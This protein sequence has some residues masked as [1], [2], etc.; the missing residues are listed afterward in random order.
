MRPPRAAVLLAAVFALLFAAPRA[1]AQ[2]ETD[3]GA[4]S[5]SVGVSPAGASVGAGSSLASPAALS[6][7][8]T[9]SLAP[10]LSAPLSA[11]AAAGAVALPASAISP[12]RPA[13]VSAPAAEP[14]AVAPSAA[15]HAAP[16]A[17]PAA[18]V[19]SAEIAGPPLPYLAALKRLGVP[20]ELAAGLHD[21]LDVR[22]PGDQNSIYHGAGHTREV[23]GFTARLVEGQDLPAA[24][25]ILLIFAAALH[26]IDPDRAPNTPARVSATLEHLDKD[27]Q[28]R[29]LVAE[30]GARYGFTADQVKALILATD[31]SPVPAE[32]EAKQAVFARAAEAAFPG[33]DFGK[34]W[35][36]RL[37][38]VD[39]ASTYLG[40]V[41]LARERVVG[42]AHE[43]R[44]QIKA[45]GYDG[46]P[47]DEQMLAG[48]YRF[49][50]VLRQSPDFALL[51]PDLRENFDAVLAYFKER[52]TPESW[53]AASAPAP[54]RA[55]PA[56]PDLAAAR[57]YIQGIAA[58]VSLDERQTDALLGDFFEGRGIPPESERAQAL[59]RALLPRRTAE[60]SAA[61]ASLP[62][63]LHPHDAALLRLAAD[64]GA[65]PAAIAAVLRRRG[66]LRRLAE[67]KPA[68]FEKQ[69]AKTLARDELE[70]ATA[71]YPESPAGD[72]MRQIAD[73][74][75]S[76]SGKSVEEVA[77]DG[78]FVY[79]DFNGNK[80]IRTR[81]GRDPDLV[82]AQVV[83][84]V[85]RKKKLWHLGVYRQNST[86]RRPDAEYEAALRKWLTRGGVPERDLD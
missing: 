66:V 62:P 28:A 83:F 36:E 81:T 71:A 26:D 2:I 25:K 14:K 61:L 80:L 45:S 74:M 7:T 46:G 68:D 47:T 70:R 63:E 86:A 42:L 8:L 78:V 58:G 13:A 1:R 69:A 29:A 67:L 49:L 56:A 40:D 6:G 18:V 38:F 79:A 44:A 52:Q 12:S 3:A 10:R 50:S 85:T 43:I 31:F 20:D 75:S 30:F 57:R 19:P 21:F 33:D 35:G 34:V 77:R 73:T 27:P 4:A 82:S 37:S 64:F 32:L 54:S 53:T 22:H 41:A 55:P 5:G 65:T 59:R 16:A 76:G 72:L 51:P 23:A 24:R 84:Y 9:T 11:P 60:E 15:G 48:S 17:T 39:Q